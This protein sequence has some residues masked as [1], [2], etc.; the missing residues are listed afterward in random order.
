MKNREDVIALRWPKAC[1]S[2]GCDVPDTVDS[3]HAIIGLFHVDK[4]TTRQDK[5]H[6]QV[7][8]K[9]P[10]FFFM[11]DNCKALI[12]TAAKEPAKN[13][14]RLIETLQESPWIA[15]IEIEK[16]GYVRL[17]DGVFKEK[18]QAANPDVMLKTKAC[19]MDK[20]K[21]SFLK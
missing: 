14:Q 11:C 15:F 2:C 19:P 3:H 5:R 13:L 17:P 16:S 6:T 4:K 18:L 12:D 7:L 1:L 21:R 10:G 8:V 9:L 20:L